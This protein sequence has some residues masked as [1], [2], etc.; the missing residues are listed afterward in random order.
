MYILLVSPVLIIRIKNILVIVIET[1][2]DL[3]V[4]ITS[5]ILRFGLRGQQGQ[6]IHSED[7]ELGILYEF[8]CCS[9]AH[10]FLDFSDSGKRL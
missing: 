10:L 7:W 4:F 1:L 9:I 5:D 2:L 6:Q 3:V 8:Q